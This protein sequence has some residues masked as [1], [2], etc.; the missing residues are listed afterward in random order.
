MSSIREEVWEELLKW[1]TIL[2]DRFVKRCEKI[3]QTG[4]CWQGWL[5]RIG[6]WCSLHEFD[7][8]EVE[9]I[10]TLS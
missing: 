2:V 3:Q 9:P 8:S 10:P 1:K 7:P 5:G 4:Q 6:Q